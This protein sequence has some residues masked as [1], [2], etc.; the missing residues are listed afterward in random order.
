MFY[1]YLQSSSASRQPKKFR[2]WRFSLTLYTDYEAIH[3][4]DTWKRFNDTAEH[5]PQITPYFPLKY[6]NSSLENI[7]PSFTILKRF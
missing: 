1:I 7:L 6:F 4:L 3:A 5:G 2:T